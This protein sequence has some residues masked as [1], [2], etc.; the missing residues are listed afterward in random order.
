MDRIRGWN[1][2]KPYRQGTIVRIL[3]T[4]QFARI[5]EAVTNLDGSQLLY[6]LGEIEGR[7]DGAVG[8]SHITMYNWNVYHLMKS[9]ASYDRPDS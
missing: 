6:Y 2:D 3:E 8:A 4:E 5:V 1:Y 7:G 9:K